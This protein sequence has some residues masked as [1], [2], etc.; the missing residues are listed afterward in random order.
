MPAVSSVAGKTSS[1]SSIRKRAY[2][3]ISGGT[4]ISIGDY[5]YRVFNASGNLQVNELPLNNAKLLIVGGGSGGRWGS[6]SSSWF[7]DSGA[8]AVIVGIGGGSGG[9]VLTPAT[10]S[11][12]LG[13]STVV[14]GAGGGNNAKGGSSSFQ[15]SGQSAIV[16]IGGENHEHTSYT[17]AYGGN[18]ES[19]SG[20]AFSVKNNFDS[21]Q[22]KP[23]PPNVGGNGYADIQVGLYPGYWQY[24]PYFM[25]GGGGAGGHNIDFTGSNIGTGGS[26]EYANQY[27]GGAGHGGYTQIGISEFLIANNGVYGCGAGGSGGGYQ[28]GYTY[29]GE[30]Y[31]T[32]NKPV[33]YSGSGAGWSSTGFL[34]SPTNGEANRGGGGGS[35]QSGFGNGGSGIVIVKYPKSEVGG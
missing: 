31:E 5:C 29:W 4:L 16:A 6:S 18:Y 20:Q 27:S 1:L 21:W 19:I 2:S 28:G 8:K 35:G 33:G 22:G 14:V 17:N 26:G 10:T 12:P 32:T 34:D 3:I 7:S 25:N 30:Y 11:I 9:Q 13:V 15:P 24:Y 23:L